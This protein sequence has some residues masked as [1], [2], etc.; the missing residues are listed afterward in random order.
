MYIKLSDIDRVCPMIIS[1]FI[2]C[3][4]DIAVI[5]RVYI[6]IY[7]YTYIPNLPLEN[8]AKTSIYHHLSHGF[9]HGFSQGNS[10][11][12]RLFRLSGDGQSKSSNIGLPGSLVAVDPPMKNGG[13]LEV[14][15]S[16]MVY[17]CL[18]HGKTDDKD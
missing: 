3:W 15:P 5:L 6:Y 14:Y 11:N 1:K 18:F 7:I 12:E 9:S 4:G 2:D 10:T 16:W 13:F 8:C 17:L